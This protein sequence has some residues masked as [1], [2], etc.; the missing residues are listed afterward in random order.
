[1]TLYTMNDIH[2]A[3]ITILQSPRKKFSK[4]EADALLKRLGVLNNDGLLNEVYQG[5][6]VKKVEDERGI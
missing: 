2:D 4:E 3:I 1:M 6:F 5:L